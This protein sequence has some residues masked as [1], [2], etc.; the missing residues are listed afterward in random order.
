VKELQQMW[1]TWEQS[2]WLKRG[3]QLPINKQT[4]SNILGDSKSRICLEVNCLATS[5]SATTC[6]APIGNICYKFVYYEEIHLQQL[7][8]EQGSCLTGGWSLLG[9]ACGPNRRTTVVVKLWY[10]SLSITYT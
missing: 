6:T 4:R 10:L 5:S 2:D 3:L 9:R 1:V 8:A 7:Q